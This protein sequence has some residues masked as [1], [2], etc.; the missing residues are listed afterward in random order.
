LVIY[1]DTGIEAVNSLRPWNF[2]DLTLSQFVSVTNKLDPQAYGL[3]HMIHV[4]NQ[5]DFSGGAW[6]HNS[7]ALTT[8]RSYF[9]TKVPNRRSGS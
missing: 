8:S 6:V 5:H 1:Y 3:H 4:V 7:F 9:L 2:I